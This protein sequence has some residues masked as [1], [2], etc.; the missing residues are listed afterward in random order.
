V[1]LAVPDVSGVPPGR[2]GRAWLHRRRATAERGREQLDRKVRILLPE[3]ERLWIQA[4]RHRKAWV[5]ACAEARTW[6]LR[7]EV[8]GGQD[9]I[10]CATASQQVTVD[11][12][13]STTMGLRYPSSAEVTTNTDRTSFPPGNAALTPAAAAFRSALLAGVRTAAAEQALRRIDAEI[14]VTRRR[15]RA[16]DKRWLPRLNEQLTRLELTL[17]QAEQEDGLRLRLAAAAASPGRDTP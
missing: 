16:L 13:W 9:G 3:R 15:L 7:A 8:L 14:S 6:L 1:G 17:E 11:V 10:R 2:A 4:V 5:S 12:R